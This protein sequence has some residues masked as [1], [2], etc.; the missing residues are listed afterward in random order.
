[1]AGFQLQFSEV[2]VKWRRFFHQLAAEQGKVGLAALETKLEVEKL[3]ALS[4]LDC[5][6]KPWLLRAD[7]SYSPYGQ[8]L[9]FFSLPC[10]PFFQTGQLE[11]LLSRFT[12]EEEMQMKRMLQRMDVLAKVRTENGF[13]PSYA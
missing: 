6:S 2:L 13:S 12:E 11:P 4:R 5:H 10:V 1:M 8:S 7:G 9:T 3:Q